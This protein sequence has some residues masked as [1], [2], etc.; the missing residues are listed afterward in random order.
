MAGTQES[1]EVTLEQYGELEVRVIK[2]RRALT[3]AQAV[4]KRQDA[5]LTKTIERLQSLDEEVK[6]LKEEGRKLEEDIV[7]IEKEIKL[8]SEANSDLSREEYAEKEMEKVRAEIK[9]VT[10]E[11]CKVRVEIERQKL[12]HRELQKTI[13][14]INQRY[15]HEG[16]KRRHEI[17]QLN[18]KE[19]LLWQEIEALRLEKA[20]LLRDSGRGAGR[21]DSN[22]INRSN[23][24]SLSDQ[25]QR[26]ESS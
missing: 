13:D 6:E 22:N 4:T 17:R 26:K 7:R 15:Q 3:H 18:E 12:C 10:L 25:G 19:S 9:E 2:L 1:D 14:I 8:E 23:N 21:S 5:A 16:K 11:H 24:A 20:K